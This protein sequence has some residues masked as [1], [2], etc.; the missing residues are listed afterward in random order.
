MSRFAVA[1]CVL[2]GA[3]CVIEAR[4]CYFELSG[5]ICSKQCCGEENNMSCLDSCEN[6]ACSSH[7]DCGR[8]CCGNGKCGPPSNSPQCDNTNA[9]IIVVVTL[10]FCV[11]IGIIVGLIKYFCCLRR[12]PSVTP[13][14]R[15]ILVN[16]DV[17]NTNSN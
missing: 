12:K 8:G 3:V 17:L 15:V 7:A 1:I 13:G 5:R 6:M 4:D 10:C 11:V 16:H 9:I 2:F 14:M